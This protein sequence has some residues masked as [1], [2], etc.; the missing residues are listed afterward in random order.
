MEVCRG[1]MWS[2]FA[3]RVNSPGP[4][5]E[6]PCNTFS[7]SLPHWHPWHASS[8]LGPL[9]KPHSGQ[10]TKDKRKN[11][12][13]QLLGRLEVIMNNTEVYEPEE[14]M[15]RVAAMPAAT[16]DWCW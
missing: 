4:Q 16:A 7:V 6:S 3:L 2:R 13:F 11:I 14:D 8:S 5:R 9:L 15:P 10:A 12:L 1:I